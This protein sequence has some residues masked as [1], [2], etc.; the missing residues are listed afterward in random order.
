MG[1]KQL[2]SLLK[3]YAP[4]CYQT[5]HL[6]EYSY[7]KVAIDISLY[8]YKYKYISGDKWITSFISLINSLRKWDIHCI[9]I[10]DGKSP[11]EKLEEQKRRKD[12]RQKQSEKIKELERQ[13]LDFEKEG[14]IGSLIEELCEKK[15]S[16]LFRK[17]VI[18][19]YDIDLAKNKLETLKSSMINITQEDIKLTQDLFDVMKIPYHQAPYEAENF[20]SHLCIYEKVDYVLSED[21]DVLA[22]QTPL[23]LTKIDTL[24]ETVV[25]ISY[26]S[27]LEETGMTSQT[28][29]DL[30][31][32]C[33]CDYNSN[34]YLIGPEKSYTLLK[35]YKTIENVLDYLKTLKNKDGSPRYDDQMF[36]PLKYER[37]REMFQT[38][39][40]DFYVSY[41]GIPDFNKIQEFFYHNNIRYNI[42]K[43]KQHLSRDIIFK[44]SSDSNSDED[45][46]KNQIEN[47]IDDIDDIND[48][49]T[50]YT[51]T[52]DNEEKIE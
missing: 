46:Y 47:D 22:Y 36:L 15:V 40:I 12:S 17:Q 49:D 10:Y 41:C 39:P 20:C 38:Y 27:I 26:D 32:M 21:T 7:K 51:Q 28:F 18:K 8:L 23:F 30:C 24:S 48:I 6:S 45:A 37:C 25:E 50:N 11:I 34:I 5:K 29:T 2:H 19:N 9:F 16:S 3:K 33:E 31:I 43:L 1:I 35:N 44:E 13:I 52:N 42:G 14:I 4:N